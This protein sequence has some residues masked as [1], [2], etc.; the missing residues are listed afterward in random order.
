MVFMKSKNSGIIPVTSAIRKYLAYQENVKKNIH[1]Y[2]EKLYLSDKEYVIY[3]KNFNIVIQHC[4]DYDE[5][6][7]Q[8][9][10]LYRVQFLRDIAKKI[11]KSLI[12][13]YQELVLLGFGDNIPE[14]SDIYQVS[15]IAFNDVSSFLNDEDRMDEILFE[16]DYLLTG[17]MYEIMYYTNMVKK[18]DRRK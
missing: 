16:N 11:N 7:F 4:C 9:E 5:K 14:K 18:L 1:N 17:R 13:V 6:M 10:Y 3:E 12:W 15:L 8:V 2:Y